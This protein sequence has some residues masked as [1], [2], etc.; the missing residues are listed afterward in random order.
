MALYGLK[1]ILYA[2]IT[3]QNYVPS[4]ENCVDPDQLTSDES[5]EEGNDQESIQA[6][7]LPEWESDKNTTKHHIQESEEAVNLSQQVTTRLKETDIT[8]KYK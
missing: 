1:S 3:F 8:D 2:F 5:K 6:S 4:F 7:T